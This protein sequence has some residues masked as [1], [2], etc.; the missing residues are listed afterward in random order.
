MYGKKAEEK[1]KRKRDQREKDI[2]HSGG[3]VDMDDEKHYKKRLLKSQQKGLERKLGAMNE[4]QQKDKIVGMI[5]DLKREVYVNED[6]VAL[7]K[8][9]FEKAR[10]STGKKVLSEFM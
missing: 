5:S 10:H 8:K 7:R 2:K 3:T 4:G 9:N 1:Q 6:K